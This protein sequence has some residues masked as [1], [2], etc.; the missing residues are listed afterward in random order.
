MNKKIQ[1]GGVYILDGDAVEVTAILGNGLVVV[2]SQQNGE[3][4]VKASRLK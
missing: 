3:E 2:E 1:I 4:E